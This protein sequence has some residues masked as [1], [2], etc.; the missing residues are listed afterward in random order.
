MPTDEIR[1]AESQEDRTEA[2][3][4]GPE[5]AALLIRG[6]ECVRAALAVTAVAVIGR[7][8]RAPG[9]TCGGQ[10]GRNRSSK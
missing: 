7:Q 6:R 4:I 10:T 5:A 1:T 3:P 8:A 2:L 9:A